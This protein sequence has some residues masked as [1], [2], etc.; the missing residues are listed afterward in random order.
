MPVDLKDFLN[1]EQLEAVHS[2]DR[3]NLVFAGAG[4]GKTRLILYKIFNIFESESPKNH[5]FFITTFTNK[6]ADELK[7]RLN[8]LLGR[9]IHFPYLGTFHS[10]CCRVLRKYA[11]AI[12]YKKDFT[13]YDED[14]SVK[15]LKKI[16]PQ[17]KRQIHKPEKVLRSI[18]FY[19]ENRFDSDEKLEE[20]FSD[21]YKE[22]EK[23]L[24]RNNSFDFADLLEKTIV[25]F[26]SIPDALNDYA[27][28]FKYLF[29]DEFQDTNLAQYRI[30]RL[31]WKAASSSGKGYMM[32]VGDENQ[33]IYAFRNACVE[34]ILNFP[35]DYP[36]SR[37]L[38]L[39]VNYRSTKNILD[40]ARP[41]AHKNPF[42]D[43]YLVPADPE[44]TG[45]KVVYATLLNERKEAE[46]IIGEIIRLKEA[47]VNLSDIAVFFRTN[48]QIRVL[49]SEMKNALIP[50]IIIGAQRF[51]ER[52]EIKDILAYIKFAV[53]GD[54]S[55][56]L[57]RIIG[58]PKR[59]IGEKTF[60]AVLKYSAEENTALQSAAAECVKKGI[61]PKSRESG[62]NDLFATVQ[63]IR[64]SPLKPSETVKTLL[65]KIEYLR[66]LMD[67]DAETFE[68]RR[69]NVNFFLREL[70]NFESMGYLTL[71][72]ILELLT[73]SSSVDSW[74]RHEGAV[75]LMTLHLSKG[76]E[77]DTVF[78]SGVE[79]GILP[80]LNCAGQKEYEEE[81]RLLYVGITRGKQKVYLT[82]AKTRFVFG[83][84][85]ENPESDFVKMLDRDILD[86][87]D[88]TVFSF[89]PGPQITRTLKTV[90]EPEEP[91]A[92]GHPVFVKGVKVRH[93]TYGVGL[94][95]G[96]REEGGKIKVD[97]HFYKHGKKVIIGDYLEI[98]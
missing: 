21:Y 43:K 73:L 77:F 38:T 19:K 22:Y 64:E 96:A 33:S 8:A 67:F 48:N 42:K 29:V 41:L 40:T 59:G 97:V 16:I 3:V 15:L 17:E 91:S 9:Q 20:E 68:E 5:D 71:V 53:N 61:V 92:P 65:E 30:L 79:Q 28:H 1:R 52:M 34:N 7:E 88:R 44:R 72:E 80:H 27:K 84:I 74:K 2:K 83:D 85:R 24:K 69:D 47:G 81:K 4:T 6:A 86:I 50:H 32:V 25:L 23:S 94:V 37:V 55:V 98:L 10:L 70:K 35:K 87:R 62:F 11:P 49:E 54:D 14:D 89:E 90:P 18:S 39:S 93:G 76:L 66:Y 63:W 57:S 46:F 56:S 82:R 13:I 95:V 36:G 51:Y 45:E 75:N 26:E 31:L 78:I 58:I 60:E 12:G